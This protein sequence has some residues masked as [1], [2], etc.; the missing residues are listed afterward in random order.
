MASPLEPVE[1]VLVL[2]PC[3]EGEVRGD[4]RGDLRVG[5]E[6]GAE[7]LLSE[8]GENSPPLLDD[9]MGFFSSEQLPPADDL[10]LL[11][12]LSFS[13]LGGFN[14]EPGSLE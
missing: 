14:G 7:D 5:S 6:R 4:R 2:F 12:E 3:H 13:L 10:L 8:E 9:T 1:A 11:S